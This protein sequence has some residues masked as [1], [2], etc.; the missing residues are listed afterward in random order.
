MT[1]GITNRLHNCIVAFTPISSPTLIKIPRMVSRSAR[2]ST[3]VTF[4]FNILVTAFRFPSLQL[5]QFVNFFKVSA[6]IAQRL[7]A[8]WASV[9]GARV[10]VKTVGMHGMPTLHK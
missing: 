2:S 1:M 6:H 8:Q 4:H 10:A 7:E 3:I 5:Q 9:F